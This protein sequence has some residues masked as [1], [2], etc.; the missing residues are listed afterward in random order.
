[1]KNKTYSNKLKAQTSLGMQNNTLFD[2]K[3]CNYRIFV[4]TEVTNKHEHFT[5]NRNK[6]NIKKTS[7][8]VGNT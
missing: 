1:M 6:S 8:L 4:G 3:L 5:T 7:N 2:N